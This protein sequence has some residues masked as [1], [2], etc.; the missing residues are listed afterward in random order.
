M[1]LYNLIA[2]LEKIALIIILQS[3]IF[4]Y[5]IRPHLDPWVPYLIKLHIFHGTIDSLIYLYI[6]II[7]II[8][9][10]VVVSLFG[11][12]E[13]LGRVTKTHRIKRAPLAHIF[14]RFDLHRGKSK[15]LR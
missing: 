2:L 13:F 11:I 10:L 5:R 6:C 9:D 12:S 4:G 3:F 7:L 15:E 8:R 1:A 14:F